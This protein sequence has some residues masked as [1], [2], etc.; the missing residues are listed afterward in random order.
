VSG[1]LTSVI[2][3]LFTAFAGAQAGSL[4]S[5]QAVGSTWLIQQSALCDAALQ[6][7]E[8]RYHLPHA[9]LASIARVESG[10]PI[11][12]LGDTR[13][14]PWTIDADGTASFFFDTKAQA[15]SWLREAER[16]GGLTNTGVQR[17]NI[18][19]WI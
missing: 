11:T 9:L 1:K 17:L 7:A 6:Q 12:S 15:V 19:L 18:N 3:M 5:E 16:N 10:R 8:S 2:A 4:G 14:W 13:P